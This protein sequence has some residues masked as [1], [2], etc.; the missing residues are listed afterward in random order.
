VVFDDVSFSYTTEARGLGLEASSDNNTS[1]QPPASSSSSEIS[2][3]KAAPARLWRWWGRPAQARSS[4]RRRSSLTEYPPAIAD[5][6]AVDLVEARQQ[7]SRSGLA[8]AGRPHQRHNLARRGLQAD[9]SE[10]EA[11]G[12]RWRLV[13]LS[14]L[15]SSPKPSLRRIAEADIVEDHRAANLGQ[16]LR[17]GRVH[18]G[19]LVDHCEDPLGPSD[20]RLDRARTAWP[21]RSAAAELGE[22][23]DKA[24]D[25]ADCRQPCTAIQPPN[26]A[27]IARPRL[28]TQFIIGPMKP[29][30]I[31]ARVAAWRS[32]RLEASNCAITT[33]RDG[34]P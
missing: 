3:C 2:A 22:E 20:G 34:R 31:C 11:G 33:A 21:A 16:W 4:C 9:I 1:L 23:G 29:A 19:R 26:P 6:A 28:F 17:V 32:S 25:R 7:D 14:L 13:L 8:C 5:L 27:T 24:G 18:L 10:D 15:A 12:W 30:K